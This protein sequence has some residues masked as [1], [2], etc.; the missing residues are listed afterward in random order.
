MSIRLRQNEPIL[1]FFSLFLSIFLS[2]CV[3]CF[4]RNNKLLQYIGK[5]EINSSCSKRIF[6]ECS[7]F[8]LKMC[9]CSVTRFIYVFMKVYLHDVSSL[10]LALSHTHIHIH[11]SFFFSHFYFFYIIS[12]YL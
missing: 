4:L 1:L 9:V 3:F 10:S 6:Y 5:R 8:Y 12:R 11:T 2:L 7:I